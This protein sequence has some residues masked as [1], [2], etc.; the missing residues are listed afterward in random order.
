MNEDAQ[1]IQPDQ[2]ASGLIGDAPHKKTRRR[3]LFFGVVVGMLMA[4]L[5]LFS[6]FNNGALRGFFRVVDVPLEFLGNELERRIGFSVLI[7]TGF[8]MFFALAVVTG[9]WIAIGVF[10]A[11]LCYLTRIGVSR[12]FVR[13]KTCRRALFI[14]AI[15]G[16][17]IGGLNSLALINRWRS[18]GPFL[19]PLDRPLEWIMEALSKRFPALPSPA[20]RLEILCILVVYW[21]IVAD[22]VTSFSCVFWIAGKR[23]E[24]GESQVSAERL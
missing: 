19:E 18:L 13:D 16:I 12:D 11:S 21:V 17:C 22:L 1:P 23:S 3:A 8:G 4:A 15:V 24:T 9:Y 14:G 7:D 2:K 6:D 20:N 10:M 5:N